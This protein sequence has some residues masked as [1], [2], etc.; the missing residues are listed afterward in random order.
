MGNGIHFQPTG[1]YPWRTATE[2]VKKNVCH[3]ALQTE[4]ISSKTEYK[5]WKNNY[6]YAKTI[7][8]NYPC[9]LQLRFIRTTI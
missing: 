3:P 2:K 4:N 5:V 7:V 1:E 9:M 8:D 6:E